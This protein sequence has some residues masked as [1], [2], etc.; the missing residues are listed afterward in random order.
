ML[1]ARADMR[2]RHCGSAIDLTDPGTRAFIEEISSAVTR[3][4]SGGD[5]AKEGS[6][7]FTVD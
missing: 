5:A 7:P 4:C 1:K 3:L 6:D 2:C